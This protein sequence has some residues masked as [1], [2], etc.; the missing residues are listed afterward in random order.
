M[1]VCRA[2]E[3]RQRQADPLAR[4]TTAVN[5]AA[6]PEDERVSHPAMW[7]NTR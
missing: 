6:E 5:A 3:Q 1:L 7:R 2:A 4:V